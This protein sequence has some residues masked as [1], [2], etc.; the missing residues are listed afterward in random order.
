MQQQQPKQQFATPQESLSYDLGI[1][2]QN[3]L[4]LYTR[5]V[6]GGTCLLVGSA[7]AWSAF[8]KVDENVKLPAFTNAISARLFY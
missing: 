6:A 5:L 2:R 3:P 8:S 7:I 4:P 1:A